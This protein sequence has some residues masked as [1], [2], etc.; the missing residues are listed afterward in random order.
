MF[1][2]GPGLWLG[3]IRASM[4]LALVF[5]VCFGFVAGAAAAAVVGRKPC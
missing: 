3:L 2:G 4:W 1:K 5:G